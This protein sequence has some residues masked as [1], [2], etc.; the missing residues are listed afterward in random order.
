MAALLAALVLVHGTVLRGPTKPVCEM[1]T[2]CSEPAA[3]LL[4]VFTRGSSSLRVHTDASGRYRI[5]LHRGTYVVRSSPR[6]AIGRGLEPRTLVV[7]DPM[8]ADF[9]MD[10]GIR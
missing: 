8:R 1:A 6:Q 5:R 9:F 10:T 7:R 3:G 4:L 2:P